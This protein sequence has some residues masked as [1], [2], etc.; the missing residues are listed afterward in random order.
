MNYTDIR[1]LAD[2]EDIDTL[3]EYPIRDRFVTVSTC[4]TEVFDLMNMYLGLHRSDIFYESLL[5]QEGVG[6][7][8]NNLKAAQA[9]LESLKV[10]SDN[11]LPSRKPPPTKG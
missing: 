6:N 10:Q 7:S 5:S 1:L 9:I 11:S 8:L 3:Q 4:L 2:K